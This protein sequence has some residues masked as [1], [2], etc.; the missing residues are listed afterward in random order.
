MRKLG[1]FDAHASK[2]KMLT[3]WETPWPLDYTVE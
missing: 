3:T 2:T 1:K